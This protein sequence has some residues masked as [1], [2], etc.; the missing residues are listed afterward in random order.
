LP[1]ISQLYEEEIPMKIQPAVLALSTVLASALILALALPMQ[2]QDSRP[3]QPPTQQLEPSQDQ[4]E[5]FASAALQVQQIRSE[6]Q[7]RIQTADSAEQAKELQTQA[8]AEMVSA[9][10]EKGLTVETYRAIAAAARDNPELASR[11][12]KLM[13]QP[14]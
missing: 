12:V 3:Q 7:T 6:W 8:A 13:E 9:V 2:A 11:I 4:I 1:R 10:K 5:S 14:R